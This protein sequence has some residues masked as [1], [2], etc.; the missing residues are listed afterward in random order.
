MA[1]EAIAAAAQ[2]ADGDVRTAVNTAQI[3]LLRPAGTSAKRAGSAG[4][5]PM[6]SC[7]SNDQ[8]LV[9]FHALG[10]VLYRKLG[11]KAADGGIEAEQLV[12]MAHIDPGLFGLCARA[13][14][15]PSLLPSGSYATASV[16]SSYS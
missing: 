12:T 1:K 16:H 8:S 13:R 3:V 6:L 2:A 9:L 10:K 4:G 5:M 11:P 14:A 15:V 7:F